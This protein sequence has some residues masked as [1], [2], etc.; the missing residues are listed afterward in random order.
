MKKRIFQT[1]ITCIICTLLMS[2]CK[3]FKVSKKSE[4]HQSLENKENIS[5]KEML[6]T[7]VTTDSFTQEILIWSAGSFSLQLDRSLP[8]NQVIDSAYSSY[9]VFNADGKH[10]QNGTSKNLRNTFWDIENGEMGKRLNSDKFLQRDSSD[11]NNAQ[12]SASDQS[13]FLK[14]FST[15]LSPTLSG[16]R[17]QSEAPL[18]IRFKTHNFHTTQNLRDSVTLEKTS[19]NIS[20]HIN[21]FEE[22]KTRQTSPKRFAWKWRLAGIILILLLGWKFLKKWF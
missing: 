17:I 20:E 13:A 5:W 16:L 12:G 9:G 2:S 4:K 22:F 21:Q 15:F 1:L 19:E 14:P 3:T 11:F 8:D 18:L 6:D 10:I 7:T